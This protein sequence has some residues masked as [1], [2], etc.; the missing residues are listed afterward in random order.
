MLRSVFSVLVYETTDIGRIEQ[1]SVYIICVR[2]YNKEERKILENFLEFIPALDLTGR[3]LATLI[4]SCL[5]KNGINCQFLVGQGY[6][7]ASAM[8]GYLHSA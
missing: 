4:V 5:Q 3:G 2:Y 1:M 7:E 8:N 6:D